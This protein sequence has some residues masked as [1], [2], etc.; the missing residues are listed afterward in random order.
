MS[1][2]RDDKSGL[3]RKVANA[4]ILILISRISVPMIVALCLWMAGSITELGKSVASLTAQLEGK[5]NTLEAKIDG[6]D[7]RADNLENWRNTF[8]AFANDEK[9]RKK[10]GI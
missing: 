1:D 4:A 3:C 8:D 2:R 9:I 10:G 7:K 6:I 5:V